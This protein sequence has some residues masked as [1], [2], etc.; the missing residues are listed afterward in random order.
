MKNEVNIGIVGTRFMGRA[1]SN[2]YN[3]A[4][5][6]FDMPV[7][8]IKHSACGRDRENLEKFT[9]RFGWKHSTTS[10]KKIIS[11][12]TIELI[13]IC[14]PNQFH[15]S[16]AVAAAKAGKHVVC[17]KLLTRNTLEARL[18]WEAAKKSGVVNMVVFNYRFIPAVMMARQFVKDG[19][20]GEVRHF[21]AVY[22]Q[23]WLT[24]RNFPI[25]WRHDIEI[26]GSGAHGD[27][28]AHTIDLARYIVGEIDEVCGVK[29]T[30][31][32]ERPTENH[33]EVGIVTAD[34][35]TCFLATFQS[36]ALGSFMA[37]R[38]APGKKN[39]LRLEIF[40]S[41]GAPLFDL[42]RL[43]ESQFY[44]NNDEPNVRGYRN[45]LVTEPSQPYMEAWW[46]GGHIIGWEHSFVHMIKELMH[47]LA[48]KNVSVPTF[49]DGYKCQQVLDA[50]M[51]SADTHSWVKID[52][53]KNE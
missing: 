31:I 29:K 21:N 53:I 1:D 7:M 34:D 30:F 19:K 48:G 51:E 46:P 42:E 14:T 37:T 27:M 22:Y 12:S 47:T 6:F 3:K 2:A 33:D 25:V 35:A 49:Y 10:W 41:E 23:D 32:R 20:I 15:V 26:S 40:G 44:S 28:N 39:F 11:D 38:L 5:L 4:P 24:D 43:N 17:E 9:R 52:E 16:I 13:D 18:M 36:G 50:V 45:I 8:P